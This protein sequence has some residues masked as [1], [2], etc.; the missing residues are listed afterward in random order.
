MTKEELFTFLKDNLKIRVE[1][2]PTPTT[3][4]ENNPTPTT[5]VGECEGNLGVKVTL[6][7]E[8]PLSGE[9]EEI[10]SD[11]CDLVY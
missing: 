10:S 6:L 3:F 1:N 8:N 2:N 9:Y 5:F 4:G 7:L 11:E